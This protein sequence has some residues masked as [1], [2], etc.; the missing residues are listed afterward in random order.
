[1]SRDLVVVDQ[2]DDFAHAARTIAARAE[3]E[4]GSSFRVLVPAANTGRG[5]QTDGA[6]RAA[7]HARLKSM[8]AELER[9]G[10]QDVT[11]DVGDGDVLV[12]IE[13][14]LRGDSFDAVIVASPR[15]PLATTFGLNLADRI[16]RAF[17]LPVVEIVDPDAHALP[18]HSFCAGV[19]T[20]DRGERRKVEGSPDGRHFLRLRWL[21]VIAGLTAVIVATALI[22]VTVHKG[23]SSS[24]RAVPIS[25]SVPRPH[26]TVDAKEFGFTL[27]KQVPAGWVDV[28]LHNSGTVAHQITFA[29]LNTVSFAAFKTAADTLDVKA[30]TGV[31]FV[32]GPNNAE[33]GQSVTATVHFESGEYGFACFISDPKDGKRHTALGMV[34][35]VKVVKTAASVEDAPSDD[36]G[37][38]SLS[39]FIFLPDASFTGNGTVAIKN[40]GTQVHEMIIAREAP[41][42]TLADVKAF[43]LPAPG[44]KPPAGPP[45]FTPSA[46]GIVALGPAQTVYEK[47]TLAPGSYVLICFFP[48]PTN[49]NRPHA[50]EGM[51][52]EFA[53]P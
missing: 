3:T 46:G 47:F 34:G 7:A 16:Q 22:T 44:T 24:S 38:I 51:I 17:D 10:V 53:V 28:T 29:K 33:P 36:G 41:G 30:L 40:V 49:K 13:D 26:I 39:E 2:L 6:N 52:K 14:A 50:L 37:S 42:K 32:G 20:L 8:M 35:E 21:S 11:G 15:E 25:A 18:G 9:E 5:S 48:D 43:L 4:F 23:S 27:P 45:P 1:M 19:G 12:A 31:D